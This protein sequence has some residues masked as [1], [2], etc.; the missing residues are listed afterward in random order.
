M[1]KM[2]DFKLW[3]ISAVNVLTE[4]QTEY[5][6]FNEEIQT[7]NTFNDCLKLAE[8]THFSVKGIPTYNFH[9]FL[10][11]ILLSISYLVYCYIK[12]YKSIYFGFNSL[13]KK[14]L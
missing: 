3:T 2:P 1:I 13:N 9:Q 6:K 7:G 14:S 10:S 11:C 12:V 5:F 4:K 8:K